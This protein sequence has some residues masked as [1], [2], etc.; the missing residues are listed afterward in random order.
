MAPIPASNA[1][2]PDLWVIHADDSVG[3]ALRPIVAGAQIG[4]IT[5]HQ[6][7]P[8]GHKLALRDHAHGTPVM[9][10][11]QPIGQATRRIRAGDHVHLHNLATGL[12]GEIAYAS[13]GSAAVAG[14]VSTRTWRGYLRADGSAAT[15]NEIWIIPTVGCVGVTAD[16][17]AREA[18]VRHALRLGRE[19][20]GIHAFAHP[21]GCSQLGDDLSSTRALLAGLATNPNAGGVLLLGLGC[22]SNQLDALLEGIPGAF[23][24]KVRT[25]SAQAAGNEVAEAGLLIDELVE[26]AACARREDLPLSALTIGLKC[27]GSDGL[28]GLTANP[29]LGRLS[30]TVA[31]SGGTVVLTEIPEI[32]GAEPALFARAS[33]SQVFAEAA[34][35]INRFKRYYLDQGLPVSG[36]PSPGNHAG[37]ITTLEEKSLGAVQKAGRAPLAEVVN[38]GSRAREPGVALLEAPGNDAIS[39]TALAAAGAAL[40]LFTTGK[41]TPLGAPVPTVKVASNHELAQ[42]KPHWIDFDAARVLDEESANVDADFLDRIIAFASGED[43]AAERNGQRTI[44]IWKRGATL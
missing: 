21:F 35:L 14:R 18:Q 25:L 42:A 2:L 36:N 24:H 6:A 26:L 28:S 20:D 11:G 37:G 29:L 1:F 13:Q 27:G 4:G 43:C 15:R 30:E 23:H 3:V 34:D 19:I 41:G 31:G 38:Y 39:S 7:I 17:V 5:V 8:A 22:E 32:F 33:S 12:S 9:K 40:V 16:L 10:Y 44:A